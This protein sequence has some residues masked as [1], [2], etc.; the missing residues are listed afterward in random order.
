MN[1]PGDTP[2]ARL[3]SYFA[4]AIATSRIG[5]AHIL[6]DLNSMAAACVDGTSDTQDAV[7]FALSIIFALH[8]DDRMDRMVTTDDTYNFLASGMEHISDAIKFIETDGNAEEA[9]RLVAALAR[10]TPGRMAGQWPPKI[11]PS[12]R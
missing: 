5:G 6:N 8:A 2:G 9:A 3:R 4:K 7:A 11:N 1:S 12:I 10:L